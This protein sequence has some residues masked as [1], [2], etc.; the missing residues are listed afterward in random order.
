MADFDHAPTVLLDPS[1]PTYDVPPPPAVA[2]PRRPRRLAAAVIAT[3]VLAGATGGAVGAWLARPAAVNA[4]TTTTAAGST[5][6]VAR[7]GLAAMAAAL[8]PAVVEVSVVGRSGSGVG[9][10]IVIAADG[11]ILTNQHVVDGAEQIRVTFSDGT[12]SAA[13]LVGEDATTDL[14]VVRAAASRDYAVAVFGDSDAVAVGDQ[15]V[16]VGSPLG[17][18]GSVTAGIVSALHRPVRA[19]GGV[20]SPAVL[21][22]IQTDAAINP[23]NSGGPLVDTS[24][25]VI[26]V[27]SAIATTG[28]GSGS[29][30]LGFAIPAN[31]AR[32]VADELMRTG[33]ARHARLGVTTSDD[34]DSTGALIRG[35]VAGGAAAAV[36]LLA[37][38]VVVEVDGVR[39]AGSDGLVALVGAHAPGERVSV[40]VLRAGAR[41]TFAVTLGTA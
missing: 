7:T 27:T 17:L 8:A 10:G 26:A 1:A 24:G 31:E 30:G 4:V 21:D 29:I 20:G 34:V 40:V 3:A 28:S 23:G 14:A 11:S 38:D 13:T 33:T 36:G 12:T 32:R 35:V 39:V 41:R 19:G 16:A 2:P 25:R 37:G 22:A 15:V 18:S 6:V 5:P 9:S